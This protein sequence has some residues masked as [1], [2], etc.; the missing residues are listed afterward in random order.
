M[1]SVF[2]SGVEIIQRP[3]ESLRGELKI[4]LETSHHKDIELS[5][6][7]TV[8]FSFDYPSIEPSLS[9]ISY[10][11][12]KLTEAE[13]MISTAQ[14]V[15]LRLASVGEDSLYDIVMTVYNELETIEEATHKK[16][17]EKTL[18]QARMEEQERIRAEKQKV[19]EEIARQKKHQIEQKNQEKMQLAYER[20]KGMKEDSTMDLRSQALDP[21]VQVIKKQKVDYFLDGTSSQNP[22]SDSPEPQLKHLNSVIEEE[23]VIR[24]E[25]KSEM[26]VNTSRFYTDFKMIKTLGKGAFGQVFKV[27][28]KLDGNYYAV[29]RM[30]LNYNQSK[31]AQ[32]IL[33]EVQVLSH[34]NHLNIVRYF[35]AWTENIPREELEKLNLC[36]ENSA[37]EE[38]EGSGEEEDIT[39]P[40]DLNAYQNRKES[41]HDDMPLLLRKKTISEDSPVPRKSSSATKGLLLSVKEEEKSTPDGQDNTSSV[42]PS[43]LE[44]SKN[45]SK[46]QEES[47]LSKDISSKSNSK[48]DSSSKSSSSSSSSNS[49][50]KSKENPIVQKGAVDPDEDQS[51]WDFPQTSKE[52]PKEQS[53]SASR[54][55]KPHPTAP[56][57]LIPMPTQ[58]PV[59]NFFDAQ[60]NFQTTSRGKKID[61]SSHWRTSIKKSLKAV[62]GQSEKRR[63]QIKYLY[64]QMECCE[65]M[66]LRE[67]IDQGELRKNPTLFPK[68]AVQILDAFTY[69]HNHQMIHRDVKPANIFLD[70]RNNIK[71]GDFG[72]ATHG[73]LLIE[74]SQ[75]SDGSKEKNAQETPVISARALLMNEHTNNVGTPIYMSP[76]QGKGGNYDSKSDMYSLGIIFFEMVYGPFSSQ[77][78]RVMKIKDLREKHQLP[79]DFSTKVG[80]TKPEEVILLL[81]R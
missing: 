3:T 39:F 19:K 66:T 57:L 58:Q 48:S 55:V 20:V 28:N 4:T 70:K 6:K 2:P 22:N 51:I 49:S 26:I 61:T 73:A 44:E 40:S 5:I 13:E 21:T 63:D 60:G 17:N 76:E 11:G 47:K 24:S 52:E 12:K 75:N 16:K 42:H 77:A 72:L 64:I 23:S 68:L 29:K 81:S 71:I 62:V 36:D 7:F 34:L 30:I 31:Q 78:E 80:G 8:K 65:L 27:K 25:M 32:K 9:L 41:L 79:K 50:S 18:I 45:S 14:D 53:N 54:E 67:V 56:S 46:Q 69:I 15:G 74:K 33:S 43:N 10:S 37:E 59:I 1:E 38:E 35:Q